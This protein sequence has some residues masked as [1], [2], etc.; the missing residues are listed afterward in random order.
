MVSLH[1][2][3]LTDLTG[4]VKEC[5]SDHCP[6]DFEKEHMKPRGIVVWVKLDRQL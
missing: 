3:M 1:K 2:G 4:S 6:M 5:V